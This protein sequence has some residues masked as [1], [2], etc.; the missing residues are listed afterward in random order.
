MESSNSTYTFEDLDSTNNQTDLGS[1]LVFM[2]LEY[3]LAD[4]LISAS[5]ILSRKPNSAMLCPD[6]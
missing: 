4:T 3:S 2:P 5:E 1:V 6:S